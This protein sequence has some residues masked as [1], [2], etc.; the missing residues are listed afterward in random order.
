MTGRRQPAPAKGTIL[1]VEDSVDASVPVVDALRFNRDAVGQ[2]WSGAE[3]LALA[4]QR[5]P[6]LILL[7]IRLPD[8]DGLVVAPALRTDPATSAIPIVAVTAHEIVGAQAK[9]PT[10]YC[11]AYAQ[12]PFTPRQ[13]VHTVA[14]APAASRGSRPSRPLG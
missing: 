3:A 2:A 7:D 10:K 12:K 9:A 6:D 4:R 5:L 13:L 8:A 1:V 11:V 14:A